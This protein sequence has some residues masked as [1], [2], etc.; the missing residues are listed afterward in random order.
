MPVNDMRW[1]KH[2]DDQ[3]EVDQFVVV[4]V[5]GDVNVKTSGSC[6]T[7]SGQSDTTTCSVTDAS[8]N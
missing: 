7:Y 8:G 2:A 3:Q 6:T 1:R 5:K 4:E